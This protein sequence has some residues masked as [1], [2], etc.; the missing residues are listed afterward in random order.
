MSKEFKDN[1]N[2]IKDVI[3]IGGGA[4]G[5]FCGATFACGVKGLILE[6]TSRPGTKLLMSGSGQCNITH[7]GSIKDF[8]PRYGDNGSKIR[9]IL[10]RH[11]NQELMEFLMDRGIPTMERE[12]G[13]VFP[14][15]LKSRDVLDM[16]LDRCKEN[17][18]ATV[19]GEEARNISK[20]K[21]IF[22]VTTKSNSYFAKKVI[23]ATGGCSYPSTGSDGSMLK[24][25][26]DSFDLKVIQPKPSLVPI[27]VENYPY[28]EA[29]GISFRNIGISILRDNKRIASKVGDVLLTHQNLSGPAILDI[30]RYVI[31]GDKIVLNY[32]YPHS[33]EEIFSRLK[34][35]TKGNKKSLDN[36]VCSEFDLPKKLVQI[37]VRDSKEQLKALAQNLCGQGFTV[38]GVSGY[39]EAMCTAGGIS[40]E[41]INLKI[42]ECKR[43]PG[44][45]LIGEVVDI[46][47]DT[48]G[49]NLQFAYS[50][51]RTCNE[52]K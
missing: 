36:I 52:T 50:S 14:L 5:L 33:L 12:D 51:A 40:L 4:A 17:G 41:E 6:K 43:V 46:D 39:K 11:N 25:L 44:L 10:Y 35:V 23:V 45:H 21:D 15:S 38:S 1:N 9:G 13:K 19:L 30:S 47:G 20:E 7:G 22:T 32:L 24:V 48:G 27:F 31:N 28:T 26:K 16:L 49:Y 8:I 29:S 2:Q 18:F 34:V 42:M 3:I 37:V